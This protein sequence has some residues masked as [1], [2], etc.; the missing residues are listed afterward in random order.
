VSSTS[1]PSKS[2]V[3]VQ[4]WRGWRI[5]ISRTRDRGGQ[6]LTMFGDGAGTAGLYMLSPRRRFND[7]EVSI[8]WFG[9]D[10]Y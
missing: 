1:I 9:E 8:Y 7:C 10:L 4:R 5:R 3:S 2:E 6:G